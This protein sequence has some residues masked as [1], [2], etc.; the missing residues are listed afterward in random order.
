MML[1]ANPQPQS[2]PTMGN[3]ADLLTQGLNV[4]QPLTDTVANAA[5]LREQIL[6]PPKPV[7]ATPAPAPQVVYTQAPAPTPAVAPAPKWVPVVIGVG[8]ATGLGL[9]IYA[10]TKKKRR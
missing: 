5:A 9:L 2:R 1:Y 4:I 7:S 3:W 6:N 8:A 10:L